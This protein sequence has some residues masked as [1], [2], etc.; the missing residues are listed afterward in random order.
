MVEPDAD[1]LLQ[2]ARQEYSPSAEEI[3]RLSA[4]LSGPSGP[5]EPGSE[6]PVG[7]GRWRWG[8]FIAVAVAAVSV[9]AVRGS[10]SSNAPN[11]VSTPSLE[12]DRRAP[13]AAP[14][15]DVAP[16]ESRGS[17]PAVP[18]STTA[19][20]KTEPSVKTKRPE[21]RERTRARRGKPSP[22]VPGHDEPEAT[23]DLASEL[24][25]LQQTREALRDQAWSK[26]ARLVARHRREFTSAAFGQEFDALDT[27]AKCAT[28][29]PDAAAAIGG[30]Y[31]GRGGAMF[32]ARVA[33]ACGLED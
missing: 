20:P 10:V 32:R 23:D 27:M 14:P 18:T 31:L 9:V 30:R 6:T 24:R 22:Q 33:E 2:L 5:P 12:D 8:A 7:G 19:N 1:T 16:S 21:P 3:E 17:R 28:A 4:R 15:V 29:K 13:V 25:L 26:V 11:V